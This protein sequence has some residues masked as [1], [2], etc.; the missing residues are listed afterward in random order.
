MN[1]LNVTIATNVNDV[2]ASLSA[3]AVKTAKR[4]LVTTIAKIAQAITFAMDVK[5]AN[6]AV[7]ARIARIAWSA[8]V[9]LSAKSVSGFPTARTARDVINV[10]FA[11]VASRVSTAD[12][13]AAVM[14]VRHVSTAHPA[15]TATM[16][17]IVMGANA[18]N[19]FVWNPIVRT[20]N[21]VRGMSS[22]LMQ[23]C[24]K[25]RPRQADGIHKEK[26]KWKMELSSFMD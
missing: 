17:I 25:V 8:I 9:V 12:V 19:A 13:A 22:F 7:P 20:L 1:A 4:A 2:T 3:S 24:K 26:L 10:T 23:T 14:T 16:S 18:V 11:R 6:T 21:R 15:T 5:D